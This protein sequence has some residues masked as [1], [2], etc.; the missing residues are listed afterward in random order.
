MNTRI[1]QSKGKALPEFL[2]RFI[3]FHLGRDAEVN[4]ETSPDGPLKC[5]LVHP[6]IEDVNF[7]MNPEQVKRFSGDIPAFEDFLLELLTLNR[8]GGGEREII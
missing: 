6:R 8:R 4:V 5:S 3:L 7:E 2:E 1:T